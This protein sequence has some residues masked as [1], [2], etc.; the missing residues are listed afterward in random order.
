[1]KIAVIDP[2]SGNLA[3][4]LRA[5]DRASEMADQPIR[6][7]VTRDAAEAAEADR[8]VLPGQGAFA[9][10]MRGLEALPGMVEV[11]EDRVRGQGV[12]LLGI[13]VGMQILVERGLEHGVTPGL[14]WIQGE[15]APMDPRGPDGAPLPLPQMGWNT[16]SFAPGEHPL[17]DGIRPGEHAYFV[18]S[19]AL[20]GAAEEEV[21]ATTEYGGPVVAIVARGNVAGT[22]F[23]VEKSA[24]LGLRILANFLRWEP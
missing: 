20:R 12:P 15:M 21:A 7:A 22:Q 10:C 3:S 4:V 1:M 14:G 5:L 16:L 24:T 2:G 8:L 11:L 6:A 19:Y 9:A 17:L 13:C 23:H 18:H